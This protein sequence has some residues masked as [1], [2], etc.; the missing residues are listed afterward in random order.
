[1]SKR[2]FA[3]PWKKRVCNPSRSSRLQ[4]GKM[5]RRFKIPSA[6]GVSCLALIIGGCPKRQTVTRV[7]YMPPPPASAAP[8]NEASSGT[9]LIEEPAPPEPVVQP[10]PEKTPE[11]PPKITPRRRA[12]ETEG[13]PSPETSSEEPSPA[14]VPALEPHQTTE[15]QS[16][17]KRK[18]ISLQQ[19]IQQRIAVIEQRKS[20][21]DG[22]ALDD[23]RAFLNRSR[24]ALQNGNLR[25]ALNLAEKASLLVD[26]AEQ[27]P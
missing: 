6:A 23:A 26:A 13:L 15:Q 9:L 1:M 25:L 8:A 19:S 27:K 2:R 21:V 24:Q 7:V 4:W 18:I 22:K 17:L 11:Q 10:V 20:S 12:T 5:E 3:V 14:E 16:D